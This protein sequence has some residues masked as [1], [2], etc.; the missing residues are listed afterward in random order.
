M[1]PIPS[2]I[3]IEIFRSYLEGLSIPQISKLYNVSSGAVFTIINEESKKDELFLFF[4]EIAKII[5]KNNL[6]IYDL[7]N[8][9][10]LN[11]II[12][13]LGLSSEFFEKFINSSNTTSFRLDMNLDDFL[14]KIK[15]IIDFEKST[16]TQIHDIL[17]FIEK[18]KNLLDE[19]R[20][21][22]ETIEKEINNVSGNI[23]LAKSQILEYIKQKPLFVRFK[24]NT[25]LFHKSLDWMFYPI[26]F[27]KASNQIGRN[28]DPQILYNKLLSIYRKPHEN[29][30]LI[31]TILDH[32]PI[33]SDSQ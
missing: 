30:E 5:K 9:I 31:R 6:N 20:R 1:R 29:S 27:E 7:I 24:E 17:P 23:G 3:K 10:H 14:N 18:E 21:E 2:D 22:K 19:L 33:S 25:D 12:E 26:L 32:N 16:Q 8:A 11:S 4:R 28:I 15:D 13:K